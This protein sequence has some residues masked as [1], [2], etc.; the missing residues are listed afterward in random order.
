MQEKKRSRLSDNR[1][2]MQYA[3]LAFQMGITILIGTFIGK[4]LDVYFQT[5]KPYYTLAGA[6]LF[7]LIA[8]YQVFR[9]LMRK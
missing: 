7:T 6:L 1:Q 5:P 2:V 3:G 9:D 8:L 4:K